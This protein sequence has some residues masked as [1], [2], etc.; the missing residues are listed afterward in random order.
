MSFFGLTALG[1]QNSFTYGT[2]GFY[3]ADVFTDEDYASA[4]RRVAS[5]ADRVANTTELTEVRD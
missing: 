4:W 3:M 2:K 5:S 1:P